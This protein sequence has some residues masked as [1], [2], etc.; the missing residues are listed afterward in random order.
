[1]NAWH[2]F[3]FLIALAIGIC[4]LAVLAIMCIPGQR[5]PRPLLCEQLRKRLKQAGF[6]GL[7]IATIMTI[8]ATELAQ[9][10][11][12]IKRLHKALTDIRQIA[13][14][15]QVMNDP[16]ELLLA[17]YRTVVDSE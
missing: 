3:A 1:M 7:A 12:K 14:R 17:I 10:D 6:G 9:Q 13:A 2:A 8:V 15:D 16:S 11:E 4:S 5:R